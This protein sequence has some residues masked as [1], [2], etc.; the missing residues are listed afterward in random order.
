MKTYEI[1]LGTFIIIMHGEKGLN[2][3]ESACLQPVKIE[4]HDPIIKLLIHMTC[5]VLE[6][7]FSTN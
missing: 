3:E 5:T 7:Q 1:M 4:S 2:E 6:H